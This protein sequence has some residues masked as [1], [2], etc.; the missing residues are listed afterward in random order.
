MDRSVTT[1]IG[2]R[3][4]LTRNRTRFIYDFVYVIL[5][6]AFTTWYS[7][8]VFYLS[9]DDEFQPSCVIVN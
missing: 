8:T 3:L 9:Y 5:S 6:L 7:D 4:V 1:F 2:T